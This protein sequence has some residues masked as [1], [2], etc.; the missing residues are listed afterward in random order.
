METKR[1]FLAFIAMAMLI[2]AVSAS[3]VFD[4]S[5]SMANVS[6]SPNP[7]VA[8]GNVIIH[9]RLYDAYDVW[10]YG[11]TLQ[12]SGTYPLLNASPLNAALLGTVNP[13]LNGV[14]YTYAFPIPSTTP[15]GTYTI[16]F[17]AQYFVYAG[18]GALIATSSMPVTFFVQNRPSIKLLPSNP[19]PASLYLGQNQ[20]ITLLINNTGYGTARNV[21]V[22]VAAGPGL[23]ILSS[24]TS[25]FVSN[26][27]RGSEYGEKLLVGAQNL[28]NTYLLANVTY[29][30]ST[31]QRRFSS[32]QRINLSAVPSAQFSVSPLGSG[33]AVGATDVPIGFRITNTGT[34]SA[35][36]LQLTL[37][38]IYPVTPV[39]STAYV[40]NLQPGASANLTFLVNVD[41][42]GVP[43]KY[44]VV[45]YEQWKQPNGA[46]NQQFTG[47][48]NYFVSVT[49][50]GLG[51]SGLSIDVVVA[52]A[53]IAVLA[54][55]YRRDSARKQVKIDKHR[56]K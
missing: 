56:A 19:Q 20:S 49:S 8:G 16:T 36:E 35:S 43:G 46:Q 25:F 33:A 39:A 29:Y 24:V 45:L 18:T 42:A 44:P 40:N 54:V 22:D 53:I 50:P 15:A 5:L 47:H 10:L 1:I 34:S 52:I 23:S 6:V 7:V 3:T 32:T 28:S 41:T 17:T 12:P 13:G 27:T 38:T 37:E 21:S 9:F 4:N 11:T 26:L 51:T 55:L 30:S 31:F 2:G 48:N 14:N